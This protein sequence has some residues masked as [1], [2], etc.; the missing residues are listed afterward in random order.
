IETAGPS[1]PLEILGLAGAPDAGEEFLVVPDERKARE[2]ADFRQKKLRHNRLS[3]QQTTK[4]ENIFETMAA[5]DAAS[6]NIVLKTDV[7]GSLEALHVALQDL[8][9]PEVKVNIVSAGVGGINESDVNLALTSLAV[10]IG[11][12]VRADASARKLCNEEGI[13]LRYYSVIYDI[14]DDVKK[15]MS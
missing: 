3:R 7:R 8:S 9:T 5:N 6:V 4:L 13:E 11:F 1:I 14:I 12:N 15:A 2:V 10:I